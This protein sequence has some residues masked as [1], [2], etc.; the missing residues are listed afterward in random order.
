MSLAAAFASVIAVPL[1]RLPGFGWPLALATTGVVPVCAAFGIWQLGNWKTQPKA[2]PNSPKSRCIWYSAIAWQVTLFLGLNSFVY[3]VAVGWFPSILAE[4]GYSPEQAG[5]LHGLMQISAAAPAL[6]LIPAVNRIHDHRLSAVLASL[7]SS[8]GLIGLVFKPGEAPLWTVLFGGGTGAT[9]ILALSFLSLRAT[10]SH[11]AAVLS[12]MA[13]C[14]GYALAAAGPPLIGA[15]REA[16]GDW[17][18]PLLLC[19]GLCLLVSILGMFAGR[20]ARIED[21]KR[22]K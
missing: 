1:A 13:Q 11:G 14:V 18:V 2:T 19:S 4:L 8:A 5:S 20:T 21:G 17:T 16:L 6:V 10:T 3:Y 9:M 22:A 7:L 15:L 12:G